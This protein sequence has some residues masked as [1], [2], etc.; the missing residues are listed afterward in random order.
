MNT[1]HTC[2]IGLPSPP[3]IPDLLTTTVPADN[4]DVGRH[5]Q[6]GNTA[7]HLACLQGHEDC[8]L[9]ILDK[10]GDEL[11]HSTNSEEKT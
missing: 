7:L 6:N 3:S 8:A 11:L 2:P 1:V 10:C 5:D 4:L 9:A